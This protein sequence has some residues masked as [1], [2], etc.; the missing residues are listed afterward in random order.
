M[1]DGNS[2]NRIGTRIEVTDRI[3][4]PD[5]P[6]PPTG[7]SVSDTSMRLTWVPPAN[8]GPSIVEYD[9]RLRPAEGGN[10]IEGT[11]ASLKG[12]E[13]IV[14]G[15]VPDA[16]Y[17]A[18]LRASNDEGISARS[19]AS[20][21][22]QWPPAPEM[23]VPGPWQFTTVRMYSDGVEDFDSFCVVLTLAT[24]VY[25]HYP[26]YLSVLNQNINGTPFY[27]GLQI[28][29]AGQLDLGDGESSSVR[30]G[31]GA[32]FSRWRERDINAIRPAPGGLFES[33]GYEGDFISVRQ[34]YPWT[35]GSYRLCLVKGDVEEG[36][37]LP[38]AYDL[39]DIAYGW[40]RFVHTWVRME[41][42]D[43]DTDET[44]FIGALAFPG[45]KLSLGNSA[46]V[47]YEIYNRW[48]FEVRDVRSF[49]AIVER[50]EVDGVDVEYRWVI[51]TPNSLAW[52]VQASTSVMAVTKYQ[53]GRLV[54]HV[55]GF[56]GA[57][58]STTRTLR[59]EP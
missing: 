17:E 8:Q 20:Q 59:R 50:L 58:G 44:T 12:T 23:T 25:G 55:G 30:R 6:N 48:S 1:D 49:D 26:V 29:I 54:T 9:Y 45:R 51:E 13:A 37:D 53:S 33:G 27:G 35:R 32:I 18:E 46:A 11:L 24:D 5:R 52:S 42:T 39:Q 38:D 15:V 19:E 41:V 10:W 2:K 47:F 16:T 34:D 43:I 3:E 31:R 21:V 7:T 36:E 14:E 4:S 57:Y 56:T 28:S 22:K 40:G